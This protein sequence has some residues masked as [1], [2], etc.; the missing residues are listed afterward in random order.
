MSNLF[1]FRD[2]V[3]YDR[4]EKIDRVKRQH[5]SVDNSVISEYIEE[6]DV[7]VDDLDDPGK[8]RLLSTLHHR[9]GDDTF[10][11]LVNE[12]YDEFGEEGDTFNIKAYE[13]D[14]DIDEES[15]LDTVESLKQD[16]VSQENF[17]YL[18]EIE[19]YVDRD[20]EGVVD[21]SFKI[22]GKQEHLSPDEILLE[23][24]EGAQVELDD[25]TDEPPAG[26][27]R[28]EEYTVEVRVYSDAGL[29]AIS[30]SRIDKTLQ[31]EIR[32]ALQR[33]G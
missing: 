7:S 6:H 11:E 31:G 19:D 12:L 18:L 26:V 32:N 9:L 13:L 23:T 2:Q 14:S 22:T 17:S 1:F 16:T 30:N 27:T 5:I 25:V 3:G 29:L 24:S 15:L 33:W 21:I 10:N 4:D 28:R 20:E 8:K